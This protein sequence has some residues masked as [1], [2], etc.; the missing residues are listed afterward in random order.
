MYA[1]APTE[2]VHTLLS[3][4]QQL[5]IERIHTGGIKASP[6][7]QARIHSTLTDCMLGF[8]QCKCVCFINTSPPWLYRG[9]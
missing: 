8:E 7:I 1:P 9:V 4:L 3:W 5:I 2:R 6:P